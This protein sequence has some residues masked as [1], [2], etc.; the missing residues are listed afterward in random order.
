MFTAVAALAVVVVCVWV[1]RAPSITRDLSGWISVPIAVAG[2]ASFFAL[3]TSESWGVWLG[4]VVLVTIAI[5]ALGA[6]IVLVF[7]RPAQEKRSDPGKSIG[8]DIERIP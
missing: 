2:V 3:R 8:P 4:S 1:Y 5:G 7:T 6:V